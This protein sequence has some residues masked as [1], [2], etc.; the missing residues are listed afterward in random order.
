M[1]GPMRPWHSGPPSCGQRL[2][3]AKYSPPMLN[4]PIS[5]PATSTI[6]HCPGATSPARA[7]TCRF[8][9][10]SRQ[11]VQRAR[12]VPEHLALLRLGHRKLEDVLRMVEVPVRIVGREH[13]PVPAEPLDHLGE[14]LRVFR[15]LDRLGGEPDMLA[16]VFRRRALDVRRL[17]PHPLPMLVHP[18]AKRRRPGEAAF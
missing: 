18:P 2:A 7:T 1:S 8:I 9:G 6:L 12:V 3:S 5:R 16:D 13:Q 11:V 14:V 10:A 15:L 17:A 4:T